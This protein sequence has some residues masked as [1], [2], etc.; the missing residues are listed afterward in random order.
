MKTTYQK[1]LAAFTAILGRKFTVLHAYFEKK[2][3]KSTIY[4]TT[5]KKKLETKLNPKY[6]KENN[7]QEKK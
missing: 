5:L 3:L 7:R 1:V 2:C 6:T 4:V